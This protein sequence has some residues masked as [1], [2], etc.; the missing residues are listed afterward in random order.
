MHPKAH[1]VEEHR[2]RRHAKL[3]KGGAAVEGKKPR[4]RLDREPTSRSPGAGEGQAVDASS[5]RPPG[6]GPDRDNAILAGPLKLDKREGYLPSNYARGGRLT[7]HERQALP[8]SDFALPG[9]GS[10][11]KGAGSGSYPIPDRSHAANA[12]ARS[13]GKPVA[14]EVRRKVHAKYPDMGED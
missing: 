4:G 10:G 7:A 2:H 12:L 5:W 8:K 13:S 14:A 11:P 3:A 9:H 6:P 1:E